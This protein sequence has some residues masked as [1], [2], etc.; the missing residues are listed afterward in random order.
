MRVFIAGIMQGSLQG[1]GIH[2]QD[3]R[4]RIA[5]VLE[6][7]YPGVEIVDPWALYPDSLGYDDETSKRVFLQNVAEAAEADLLVAYLP[8]ASMGTAVEMWAAY[9]AGKPVVTI[10]PLGRNWVVRYLS[11]LVVEDLEAFEQAVRG[12]LLDEFLAGNTPAS[13]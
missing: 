4:E 9:T 11:R 8:Q 13:L 12:G 10:S 2:G 6:E 7:A 1:N 5:R 3:Y